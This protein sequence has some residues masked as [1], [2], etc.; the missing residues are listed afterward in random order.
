MGAMISQLVFQPPRPT[1]T[2]CRQYT[3]LA[4]SLHNRIATFYIKNEGAKYTLLFSHGNA[5]DLGM[6]YEWF[7]EVSRRINVNVMAYDYTGYGISL[8][9]PSEEAV[10]S[11][12]EAAFAYLVDVKKTPPSRIILYGRSLGTGPSCYLAAKQSRLK[13]PVGG[14]ILQSPLL[15][16]YRVAF[17]FRFSLLGDMFCNIDHVGNIESPI[18]IIHGTRDEVI[19]FWHGEE[20]FVACQ[21]A[22]RSLPLWVQDAGHNNIEAF[23]GMQGD[24]FFAHLRDF[25][26]LCHKTNEFRAADE[27]T[28]AQAAAAAVDTQP[29]MF[30]V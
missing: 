25:V 23:L 22:W 27:Q 13:A 16:I 20:L 10:Y 5:E 8:G 1:Y 9:V 4:T 30:M 14:V 18:T 2:S 28:I 11:D 12:V 19:P 24:S 7:R 17:Q 6:V 15:S 21:A 29:N 3:M 26:A